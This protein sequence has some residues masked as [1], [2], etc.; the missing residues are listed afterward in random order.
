MKV[1]A[2]EIAKKRKA[3]QFIILRTCD[4]GGRIPLAIADGHADEMS[5]SK[6]QT[7]KQ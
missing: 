3:G 6:R 2:P 1:E 4:A 5:R 7:I